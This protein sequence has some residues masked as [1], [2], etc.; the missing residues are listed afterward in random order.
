MNTHIFF[1]PE[2]VSA[3]MTTEQ[4][5][6]LAGAQAPDFCLPDASGEDVCLASFRG[7]WVV[8]YFYPRDNTPGCTLEAKGFTSEFDEFATLGATIIGISADTIESHQKFA[9]KYGLRFRILSD[10]GHTVLEKYGVWQ[11]K[12]IFGKEVSGV[13]RSTFLIGPDG[14]IEAVWRKVNVVG[15]VA[16]VKERLLSLSAGK[17]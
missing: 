17:K 4:P 9:Q 6:P 2:R 7:Q 11:P 8:L 15:H 14:R 5:D 1:S 3:L 12:R 16:A 13:V 10:T